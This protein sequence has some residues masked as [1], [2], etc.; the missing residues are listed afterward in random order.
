MPGSSCSVG[1]PAIRR[2]IS[3]WPWG[4]AALRHAKSPRWRAFGTRWPCRSTWTS[5][6]MRRTPCSWRSRS[7]GCGG[8]AHPDRPR[9]PRSSISR[10]RSGFETPSSAQRWYPHSPAVDV[11]LTYGLTERYRKELPGARLIACAG[12]Y[13]TAAVLALQP[14]VAAGL[15]RARNHHR[16]Q[17]RRVR[18]RKDAD[19]AHALLRVPR[20]HLGLRGLLAP[21]CAPK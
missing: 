14:L 7:P 18:R 13:P 6:A 1:W 11:P 8:R 16:R 17:V 21:A 20:Q 10:A 15:V 9:R 19:R 4:R 3:G 2:P 5:S 12:C